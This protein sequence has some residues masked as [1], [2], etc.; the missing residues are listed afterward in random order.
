M[1]IVPIRDLKDTVEIERKCAEAN[2]TV[3]V[4]KNGYGRLVVMDIEYYERVMRKIDE[5]GLVN[6]GIADYDE[7]RVVDDRS[8]IQKLRKKHGIWQN[9]IHPEYLQ[10]KR[11][12]VDTAKCGNTLAALIYY[13]AR[14]ADVT[15][16]MLTTRAFIIGD[17]E[18]NP[19][20]FGG[21]II[22]KSSA[23]AVLEN[24]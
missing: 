5:A 11:K 12:A 22:P 8:S 3:F 14:K 21:I 18:G 13:R 2:G 23:G 24:Y 17:S 9:Y 4:T 16:V 7:G 15:Y 19:E 1:Q 10:I 6:N 20:H